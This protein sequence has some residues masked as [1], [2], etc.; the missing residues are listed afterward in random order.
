M[1]RTTIKSTSQILVEETLTIFYRN[2]LWKSEDENGIDIE[3]YST[4]VQS[5]NIYYFT[6]TD[7]ASFVIQHISAILSP[8]KI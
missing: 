2:P 3:I 5:H 6:A 4:N 8:S 7:K 1:I